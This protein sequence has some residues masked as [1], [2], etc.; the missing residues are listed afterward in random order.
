VVTPS[1]LPSIASIAAAVMVTAIAC[2]ASAAAPAAHPGGTVTAQAQHGAPMHRAAPVFRAFPIQYGAPHPGNAG[3]PVHVAPA[4]TPSPQPNHFQVNPEFHRVNPAL[5]PSNPGV[6]RPN[7]PLNAPSALRPN[8]PVANPGEHQLSPPANTLGANPGT[9]GPMATPPGNQHLIQQGATPSP[10]TAAQPAVNQPAT[11]QPPISRPVVNRPLP[12]APP[13]GFALAKPAFPAVQAHDRFWPLHKDARFM[14]LHGQRRLFTPVALL[15]VAFIGGSYWYPDAYVSAEGPACT[16]DTADGCQLQWRM[17]DLEDGGAEP[18]CVQY[19]PQ[20]GPPPAEVATLPPPAPIPDGGTCQTT[21][22][23]EPNF[24]GNSA[25]TGDSQPVLS[26]TGWR[27]EIASIVVRAGTWDFFAD[28]NYGGESLRFGP[29]T[30]PTLAPE[31]TRHIGSFM[32]VEP[33]LPPA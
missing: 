4:Y 30:Y 17:V 9:L 21:I 27:N 10:A 29:G 28:E 16:G 6:L 11:N 13:G 3:R 1:V 25:P 20:A 26:S 24:H 33:G 15:G 19:C 22:Y 32:C 23:A 18:Q 12:K 2:V 7:L 14:W 8:F 5:P 31:W